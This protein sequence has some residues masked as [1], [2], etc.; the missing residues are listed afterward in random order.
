MNIG[1]LGSG[2]VGQQLGL[3]FARLGHDVKIGTRDPGKL[4][5]WLKQIGQRGAAG[6][7]EDAAKFG[8]VVVLCTLWEGTQS[9][10]KLADKKNFSG[11]V[12]IDVTNPLDFSK[13]VP[14]AFVATVGNSGGEQVQRWLPEAK[15][16][17]AFNTIGNAIMCNPKRAE[18][19][20]DLFIAGD[21]D[22]AKKTVTAFA[23]K[24]GW[25]SVIDMGDISQ[26][27]WLETFAMLWI[28]YG[29][30]FNNWTHA[31]KLLRK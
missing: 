3:G 12:V 15:V 4:S 19:V 29:F 6:S 23:E 16:V 2:A 22:A 25:A 7:F 10:I 8:E 5:D 20:P 31:F 26:S 13:G 11:K 27:F 21:D 14:P 30:K 17:K 9:A 24:W 28:H 1:I 18:G